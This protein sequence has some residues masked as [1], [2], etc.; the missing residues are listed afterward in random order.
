M[1]TP[2]VTTGVEQGQRMEQAAGPVTKL[3]FTRV[4]R[5]SRRRVFDAWTRPEL[6][7]QWLTPGNI[8]I[9]AASM[10]S[11][12]GGE[13]RLETRGS[14]EVCLSTA[15]DPEAGEA[16]W[17]EPDMSRTGMVSGTYLEVVPHERLV[18]TWKGSW[19]A[20]E[21]S[22]VTVVLR[23]VE[24]GT[25]LTLTHERFRTEESA[26]RHEM[27]WGSA[28]GKLEKWAQE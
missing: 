13:Y 18:F 21:E 3:Q 2:I 22:L 17:S 23:D 27:G 11:R 9:P 24:G 15:G 10:D 26:R 28:L 4:I 1:A 7:R 16:K 25:E 6:V 19:D 5:A 14:G 20:A 8:V 12:V